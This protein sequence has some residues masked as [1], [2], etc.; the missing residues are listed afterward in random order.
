VFDAADP[1]GGA[2]LGGTPLAIVTL[3]GDTPRALAASPDGASVY[4]AVFQSG[5]RTTTVGEKAVC[6][7]G[8][9]APPC[10]V[11][12]LVMPG[13]LPG[14]TTNAEG[15]PAPETGLIVRFDGAAWTD[16]LGRAWDAAVRFTLPDVDVFRIDAATL[17]PSAEYAHVGTVLYGMAV[18]P[19]TGAV[20]V[21]NTE[22]QNHVRFEGPGVFGGSTVRGHQ[23]ESRITVLDGATVTPRRLNPHID[24]AVVPSPPGTA[25]RSLALPLGLAVSDDGGTLWVAAFGSGVVARVDAAA[26]AAGTFAPDPADHV[27]V[28]GGGPSG[29]VLDGPRGRLYVLTRFD[30][31][32]S[33]VDVATRRETAHLPLHN[34]EPAS[35]VAGR[36]LLYDA[37]ATSSN[38]EAACASC[39]VFGDLDGL[40]WDL[41]NPDGRV[42]ANPNPIHSGDPQ[43]FHPMKGPMTTQSLRGMANHGAMHWRGDRTG[44]SQVEGDPLAEDQAFAEFIV[45]FEGLL[46]RGAPIATDDMRRFG[47]F[48]LQ[49]AY[50]PNPIRALDGT[51]GPE[52]Q[53]GRDVFFERIT[54]GGFTCASCHTLS[55]RNGFFGTDGQTALQGGPQLF[56]IPHLRNLYQKVGMFGGDAAPL[57]PQ[58]RGFG[59]AH[60]GSVDTIFRFLSVPPFTIT[61]AHQRQLEQFLLAFDSELAPSV[62]QQVTLGAS[63]AA[64]A[65]ARIDLLRARA[66]AGDCDLVVKGVQAGEA[67]GWLHVKDD[68]FVADRAA[69]LPLDQPSL[70]AL[71]GTAGQELTWTCVPPGSGP[72]VAIDRDEDGFLDRDELDAGTD[73]ADA[74]SRPAGSPLPLRRVLVRTSALQLAGRGAARTRFAFTARTRKDPLEHRIAPPPAA[75]AFDPTRWGAALHVYNAAFTADAVV[76]DLAAS[77]WRRVGSARRPKGFRFRGRKGAPIRSVVL[78][79]N[80]LRVRGRIPYSLDE[81]AQ[82][83]VAVRLTPR[84]FPGGGWC[85][86]APARARG[87]QRSTARSDRP[88]RFRG[89]AGTAP[90]A[91][92]PPIPR[93]V[94][95]AP[96]A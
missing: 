38:G 39:H 46:G 70:G 34:P 85:A 20:Y 82:G 1:A 59:F 63:N 10:E 6:D 40:A 67:R 58:V 64:A 75:T 90:P 51:L 28:T 93:A 21:T 83:R 88:G 48:A 18:N 26:L 77:G 15:V 86:A 73:P 81:P 80:A 44:G 29:V 60:D 92:C 37:R 43:P 19:A 4:A 12:G 24:Y 84:L 68:L 61:D 22:A 91:A 14:P 13:G 31:A 87:P 78:G 96:R 55:P 7:G 36:P 54:D 42:V 9:A 2:G 65:G 25:E 47:D 32:V 45:A 33:V 35:V 16:P 5:N 49:I 17:A 62:G 71:A 50:P 57:G 52:Q 94:T 66:A 30:N 8:P 69:E 41:G 76:A 72:R 27:T 3:L 79:P 89:A 95:A 56:K 11:G 53:A 74:A 23:H